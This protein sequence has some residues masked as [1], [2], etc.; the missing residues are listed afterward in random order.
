MNISIEHIKLF[1][2]AYLEEFEEEITDDDAEI[3]ICEFLHLTEILSKPL[4]DE[5][6]RIQMPD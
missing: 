4:P 3:L 6:S 5:G 2:R 1:K